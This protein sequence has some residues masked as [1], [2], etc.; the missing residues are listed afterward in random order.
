VSPATIP[1]S[2]FADSS[3]IT[4]NMTGTWCFRAVYT[5]DISAYTGSSD[6]SPG[7]CFTVIDTTSTSTAQDWLPN[8]SATITSGGSPLDGNVTFTLY[9][10]GGCTGTVLYAE[11][12][13][14]V[15]GSTSMPVITH[16][17]NVKV[18]ATGSTTVSWKVVYASNNANV[19]GSSSCENTV[20]NITN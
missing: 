12:P 17:T 8:D 4:A 14:A 18:T 9:N 20:L 15:S 16:N 11:G 19:S 13:I 6:A 2:S 5:P 1:P 10:A 3:A 7:E